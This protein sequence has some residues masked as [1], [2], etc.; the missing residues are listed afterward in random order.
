[1]TGQTGSRGAGSSLLPGT[2]ASVSLVVSSAARRIRKELRPMTWTVLEEVALDAVLEDGRLISRTSARRVAAQLGVDPAT[3]AS[4]LR[5]LRQRGFLTL[6]R[7]SGPAG[8]FGLSLYVFVSHSGMTVIP[9]RVDGS[10]MADSYMDSSEV[11]PAD[12]T[13]PRVEEPCAVEAHTAEV[14]V[15]RRPSVAKPAVGTKATTSQGALD[16]GLGS[17]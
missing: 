7:Q 4:S 12:T 8:R 6:E 11:K 3:A 14:S 9:P 10:I 17:A 1:M 5:L 16:L 15:S 13:G 2:A